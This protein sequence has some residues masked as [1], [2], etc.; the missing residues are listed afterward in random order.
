MHSAATAGRERDARRL[1]LWGLAALLSLLSHPPWVRA[2]SREY[3]IKAACV[4]NFIRFVDWPPAA[5]PENSPNLVVGLLGTN[6]FGAALDTISGKS[7][8]GKSIVIRQ[9]ANQREIQGCHVLFI[10]PSEKD[11]YRPILESL[12]N[13]SILTV[14]EISGFARDGGVI[15]FFAEGNRLRFE[16]SPAAAE[17]ARL[18][19][20][21]QLLRLAK[22]VR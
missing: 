10:S 11:R 17:R 8:K 22:V 12:R 20:S 15:N 7:V 6:V 18:T 9:V 5:L 21:S 13:D 2:E 14:S 4:L 1:C 3:A 19:V 16:I